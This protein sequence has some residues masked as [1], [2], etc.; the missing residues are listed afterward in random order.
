MNVCFITSECTPF[1]KTGGLAD[2]SAALPAFLSRKGIRVKLF[3]PLYSS[4]QVLEY[5]FVKASELSQTAIAMGNEAIPIDVWYGQ[6]PGS[7]VDVYLIDCPRFFHR[8]RIYTDDPDEADRFILLQHA[9]FVVMQRYNFSPDIIHSNDWQTALMPAML[10][11]HYNWDRLFAS[12]RTVLSIH[13]LAYQGLSNP[14]FS[15]RAGLPREMADQGGLFEYSG[16]FSF[17]KTGIMMADRL[18]T[19]SPTYA[20]EIQSESFGEGLDGLLRMRSGCLK[21]IINGIDTD[22]WNP[23]TDPHIASPFS[24]KD[25]SGKSACRA[26]LATEMGLKLAENDPLIG[27]VSRFASQ[28]GFD[29]LLSVF[30]DLMKFSNLRFAIL[31]SG[32]RHFEYFFDQMSAA[33]PGRVAVYKGF[34]DGLAHRIEAG[35]DMFLMPSYYEPCGLN[36]MY[37]LRY[38]TV[39]I[40]HK[41]GGLAD[42]VIDSDEFPGHGTGFSFW[43]ATPDVLKD[44]IFRALDWFEDRKEWKNIQIRGMKTDFSWTKSA[45]EYIEMYQS[46]KRE[47]C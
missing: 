7:D 2:V 13:N 37:S 1:A 39:P 25:L 35:S 6:I 17:L 44:T 21:G 24:A 43:N 11:Y 16:A 9:A 34:N 30:R 12:T 36:Q 23:E 33:Y 46:A 10:K 38:G 15:I 4:I 45:D 14:D 18:S 26:A 5:G 41:T 29:L 28:K 32:D 20:K 40:V 22:I 19:V 27:I 3:M 31:G 47:S 42:T 8:G